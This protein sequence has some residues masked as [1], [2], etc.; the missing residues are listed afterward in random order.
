MENQKKKARPPVEP[1]EKQH[2]K[3][4][5]TM[6]LK[7]I[8]AA[9]LCLCLL[10]ALLPVSALG[11][12]IVASG[13]C[14]A[15]GDNLTWTLD[16]E[17]T[18]TI[19]G[20][21][22]MANY[23]DSYDNRI[24]WRNYGEQVITIILENGVTSIGDSAFSDCSS[25]T[26]VTIPDSVTSIGSHAFSYCSSL[27]SVT[28]PDSVT[29]IG[30]SAFYDCKALKEVHITDISAWC[31][32]KFD[33]VDSNPLFYANNLYINGELATNVVIPNNITS[34]GDYAFFNYSRLASVTIPD[35]VTSIG[36]HAFSNCSS[37]TSITI[38]DSVTSIG[39]RAFHIC[40]SLASV[41][42]PGSVT[43]I[44]SYAFSF[45]SS[46][47]SVTILDGV[48][49]IGNLTFSDCSSLSSVTIP[50][51]VTSIGNSTFSGCSSLT[52]VTIP[53][54]VTSIGS[55]TFSDC[56]SLTSVTIPDSVTSI[57]RSAF[58]GC[59]SLTSITIPDSV[60]SIG[61]QAFYCCS[62]LTSVTIPD[63]VTSIGGSAF[64]G[65]TSLT[66]IT[67]PDSVTS[68]GGG[69]FAGCY[70]LTSVIIPDSVT[71]IESSTF[72][73]CSSLTSVTIPDSVTSIG[74]SAF[75]G[76]SSLTSVTIPDSVTSIGNLAFYCCG[77]LT[78]TSVTI[79]DSV[80][81]IGYMVF[82]EWYNLTSVTVLNPSCEIYN[83]RSDT[84]GNA[85]TTT[86]YGY[87]NS[88]AQAYAEKYGYTFK[89]L[90]QCPWDPWL[91]SKANILKVVKITPNH[92]A[93]GADTK[94]EITFN[95]EVK[96]GKGI[97]ELRNE[98]GDIVGQFAVA[99]Y[100]KNISID[101]NKVTIDAS[102]WLLKDGVYTATISKRAFRSTDGNYFCGLN[103]ET[104]WEF[105]VC[106][107]MDKDGV[108]E[109]AQKGSL[110]WKRDDMTKPGIPNGTDEQYAEILLQWAKK[111]GI[112]NLTKEK[113]LAILDQ[114]MYLPVTDM[115]GAT[116]LLNDK[117]T[118]VR[119]ALEDILFFE[120]LKPFAKQIDSDLGEVIKYEELTK[121]NVNPIRQETDLYEKI[122]SWYP[123][124][125]KYLN[126][127]NECNPFYSSAAAL[128]Y[129]TLLTAADAA[130]GEVY[131]Y[132]KPYLKAT[133]DTS[134]AQSSYAGL[135]QYADYV[136]FKNATKD[137]GTLVKTL[138]SE[139]KAAYLAKT[140]TDL[141]GSKVVIKL[142]VDLLRDIFKDSGNSTLVELSSAWDDYDAAMSAGKL[143]A[144]LG[145]S[146]GAFPLVIDLYNKLESRSEHMAA[147]FYFISDY[148]VQEKYPSIYSMLFDSTGFP[149]MDGY[150]LELN[151]GESINSDPI[152]HNWVEYYKTIS[153]PV[154]RNKCRQL[155]FDL[156]NYIMLLQYA[157]EF[158]ANAAKSAMARYISAECNSRKTTQFNTSCPVTVEVYDKATDTLVA[159]L[160]S[161]EGGLPSCEYG[162]LYLLG[163]N[164]ETKC[165][166]L[167]SDSYY[168]KITPYDDGKMNV[169]VVTTDEAGV[170]TG[171]A[172]REVQLTNGR[173]F[174]LNLDD[175]E[176]G[177]K[178]EGGTIVEKEDDIP[179][180]D[181]DLSAVKEIAIGTT[182]QLSA[183]VYPILATNQSL[184]WMSSDNTVVA[185]DE[186]GTVTGVGEGTAT[187]SASTENGITAEYTVAAY[188][189]A[190]KLSVNAEEVSMV[191]EES[192]SLTAAVGGDATHTVQW[193]TSNASIVTVSQ[194]G[195]LTARAPG[196]AIVTAQ[197]DGWKADVF[198]T[199]YAMQLEV[200]MSQL[201]LGKNAVS[202]EIY[203]HSSAN[204]IEDTAYIAAYESG[205]Q[206]GLQEVSISLPA[207]GSMKGKIAFPD[208]IT[209]TTYSLV[210]YPVKNCTAT[211]EIVLVNGGYETHESTESAAVELPKCQ[212]AS[213]I[214]ENVTAGELYTLY[215]LT[216]SSG[217]PTEK[218]IAYISRRTAEGN[219]IDF[220]VCPDKSTYGAECYLYLS[221]STGVLRQ[222]APIIPHSYVDSTHYAHNGRSHWRAC[223]VC[224]EKI[225]VEENHNY[226]GENVCEICGYLCGAAVSGTVESFLDENGET[227][228]S[229]YREGETQAAYSTSVRS[230][231]AQYAFAG[232][233]A[234]RYILRVEK[235]DHT[236]R[237]YTIE[238][239][240]TDLSQN[241]K[242][243]PVGDIN[244]DGEVNMLD[245]I[246]LYN[247]LNETEP[248][249]GYAYACADVNADGEAGMLDM[250]RL[251]NHINETELLWQ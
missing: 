19:S 23:F 54:S 237:E 86:I 30:D 25:L 118:T 130:R 236:A 193:V 133:L 53:D 149:A 140:N 195:K 26:S 137:L 129:Q 96:F 154:Q 78:N 211:Q 230:S 228:L 251:Y 165:F 16:S 169:S 182:A 227:T 69:A 240:Q 63:S 47:T 10:L 119:Q 190:T 85:K 73:N 13:T 92:A 172:F 35:S 177:L 113:A 206:I 11:A 222:I 188:V 24:P 248:L 122:L 81:S 97:I 105:E 156:V 93:V 67:I 7:R 75:S 32:I 41:T 217:I 174:E 235:K 103:D 62:G 238:V 72:S 175:M 121:A 197:I 95:K 178:T 33:D 132:T 212:K 203:N 186:N 216:D 250:I 42:I 241:V 2:R 116:V 148:Y 79:P 152:L 101:G 171:K 205:R 123:Q 208:F 17:G 162:T 114:P 115:N 183:Q 163:E 201:D 176:T 185:V 141:S 136:D 120:S 243:C 87:A 14:G 18:L 74:N 187:I 64:S 27:T 110:W 127:R 37:L 245:M 213:V 99:D 158:N 124:I 192:Y 160:S 151:C 207:N 80:T 215:V 202:L 90:D 189:P 107:Y 29:S 214:C 142:G 58:D 102:G 56:S 244:G 161:A 138:K 233:A 77:R 180:V 12:K 106:S 164:N 196:K 61:Q 170:V 224:G 70:D 191:V 184:T 249:E 194:D 28:I 5:I 199:V 179:V 135:T 229:L 71:S 68:I 84:L 226:N 50:D 153:E 21:G 82:S 88:T 4:G 55:W 45:C 150:M 108:L 38:P 34:I 198:V 181:I 246:G 59:S 219:K 126:R 44:G 89:T 1:P 200:K 39:E 109:Y 155:R 220:T 20:E 134:I 31:N 104:A 3:R 43:S 210:F 60:T 52:S 40:S 143:C 15:N 8:F 242:I 231:S 157:E 167:D 234:G 232:V 94:F 146:L 36:S 218:N 65:C 83:N 6:K 51:G 91:S 223:D 168:A 112:S 145:N 225:S 247:H 48:T 209:Q 159:S 125:N 9:L 139:G 131:S 117:E 57:G 147:A 66:S 166:V 111:S 98:R 173:G 144:F 239:A 100:V 46:L 49:S 128:A 204:S 22:E 221:D 76:C